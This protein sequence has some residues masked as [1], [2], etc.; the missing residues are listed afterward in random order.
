MNNSPQ[1]VSPDFKPEHQIYILAAKRGISVSFID[2]EI[3]DF[4][5]YWTKQKA[6]RKD[7]QGTFWNRI[8]ALW[9][10][11]AEKRKKTT[12]TNPQANIEWQGEK[13]KLAKSRPTL[14][15]LKRIAAGG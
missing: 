11:E 9:S 5:Y 1:R 15:D 8:K 4:I 13:V 2:A 14:R 10:Y 12:R 6:R 7:W 3:D